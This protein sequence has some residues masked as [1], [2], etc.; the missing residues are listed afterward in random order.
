LYVNLE[1]CSHFGKTPPC[2]DVIIKSGIKKVFIGMMDPNPLVKGKGI[3]LLKASGIKVRVGILERECKSFNESYIKF[4]KTGL[5]FVTMKVAMTLD[6]KIALASGDSKWITSIKARKYTHGL[7]AKACGILVGSKT[8]IK[9]NPSLDARLAKNK[10]N[11]VKIILDSNLKT[12]SAANVYKGR[13]AKTIVFTSHA[14]S[15]R[16]AK[17]LQSKG[18]EVVFVKKTRNHLNLKQILSELGA[19]G[20]SEILVEGG[21]EVFSAFLKQNLV[22]KIICVY[23]NKIVG[24]K[25]S[26]S[27]FEKVQVSKLNQAF[28]LKHLSAIN[29]DEDII[30]TGYLN[31]IQ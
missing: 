4:I 22:D 13:K 11:P 12:G 7:R 26:V 31:N 17:K 16:K 6:G 28:T 19:Q 29:L 2:A 27:P 21:R 8:V 15:K 24:G 10:T 18:V 1:P 25:M 5:P 3:K 20:L 30:V 14:A 23:G 9:D